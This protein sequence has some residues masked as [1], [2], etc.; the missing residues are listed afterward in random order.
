MD[1][2]S[3]YKSVV[4]NDVQKS[5]LAVPS[6]GVARSITKMLALSAAPSA[7]IDVFSGDILQYEY[8]KATFKDVV[9]TNVIE[10]RS[11]QG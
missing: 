4:A 5:S 7:D 9:E 11:R 1:E 8:F 6:D 2:E 3:A 10:Q